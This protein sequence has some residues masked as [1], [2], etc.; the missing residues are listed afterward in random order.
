MKGLVAALLAAFSAATMFALEEELAKPDEDLPL[1]IDPPLLIHNRA[2]DGSLPDGN[3]NAE[4]LDVAKIEEDLARAEKNAGSAERLYK[5]GII[6]KVEAEERALKVVRLRAKLAEARV[7]QAKSRLEELRTQH[8]G[9]V[10]TMHNVEAADALVTE[11]VQAAEKAVR[12]RRRA[13]TEAAAR[14]VQRQQKL[15]ARGSGRKADLSKA[16]QRLTDLQQ[17]AQ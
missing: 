1:E 8:A 3:P 15:L 16:Q 2:P 10:V 5:V 7:Q 9:G 4:Q 6:S 11:T 14:N 13:E 17:P 12:D